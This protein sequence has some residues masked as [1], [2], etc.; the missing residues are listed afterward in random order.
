MKEE[1][2]L[3]QI[4]KR[5]DIDQIQCDLC[6]VRFIQSSESYFNWSESM[7][8]DISG[9]LTPTENSGEEKLHAE[10]NAISVASEAFM[11]HRN[12]DED[13]NSHAAYRHYA[14]F[15]RR[16]IDP[17]IHDGLEVVEAI[18]E[19]DY[20]RDH[21]AYKEGSNLRQMKIKE[22]IKKISDAVEEIYEKKA[23]AKA[24]EVMTMHANKLVDTIDDACKSMKQMDSHRIT[25]E[26]MF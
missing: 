17:K 24:E 11:E 6:G 12:T 23:W 7:E 8:A 20:T 19:R 16:K 2:F 25:E 1:E 5:A 4:F 22:N 15:F 3:S 13:T 26:D 10:G 9:P 18:T 14:E 21:L